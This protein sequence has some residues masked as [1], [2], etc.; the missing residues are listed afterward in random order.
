MADFPI[1]LTN[2]VD[3][4]NDVMAD[5]LNNLE[6]KVGIDG[7]EVS[8]SLDYLLKN[9]ASKNP[10]HNHNNLT[11][12]GNFTLTQN[13]VA[14]LTS[15]ESGAVVTLYLKDGFIGAGIIPLA[16]VHSPGGYLSTGSVGSFAGVFRSDS[17]FEGQSANPSIS[18]LQTA[19]P[20][21]TT[22]E[23]AHVFGAYDS[24]GAI[25]KTAS[26]SSLWINTDE[27]TGFGTIRLN[28]TY[29]G[30][31]NDDVSFVAFGGHGVALW[32]ADFTPSSA[33]GNNIFKVN[34]QI[35]ATGNINANSNIVITEGKQ[36]NFG[37]R[38]GI[39]G[40]G[41]N[42]VLR[43]GNGGT[44]RFQNYANTVIL[45]YMDDVTGNIGIGQASTNSRLSIAGLPTS[46]S[47]LSPGD[48]WNNGG[49]LNIVT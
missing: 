24:G 15:V 42:T 47:G 32:P 8:T 30:G 40:D 33:P 41:S 16:K 14:V 11:P 10:G 23:A 18:L 49:V 2:A 17:H 1:V 34:G 44:V 39:Y 48:I 43:P 45:F 26:I 22:N 5:H 6:A 31:D 13:G 7:S 46:A 12:G 9:A 27:A 3:G 37:S 21:L 36:I 35:T 38:L 4:I 25:K 20:G 29:N 19:N 28:A